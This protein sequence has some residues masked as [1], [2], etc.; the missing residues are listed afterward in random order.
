MKSYISQLETD[1]V[2]PNGIA[3]KVNRLIAVL[4]YCRKEK[5]LEDTQRMMERLQAWKGTFSKKKFTATIE[6]VTTNSKE[7]DPIRQELVRQFFFCRSLNNHI[8]SLAA[9]IGQLSPAE[10]TTIAIY[11]FCAMVYKNWQRLGPAIMLTIEEA[12]WDVAVT[13]DD[14]K[15]VLH[16]KCHKTSTTYGPASLVLEGTDDFVFKE[17]LSKARPTVQTDSDTVLVTSR[18]RPL[19]HYRYLV[20]SLCRRFELEELPTP[21]EVRKSGATLA[22][23]QQSDQ[24][25]MEELGKHMTHSTAT[26]QRHYRDRNRAEQAVSAFEKMKAISTGKVYS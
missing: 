13:R 9:K 3:T 14:G 24:A 10:T 23:D 5:L 20:A 18:G 12:E 8:R 16:S 19:T 15:L 21:T 11:L 1:G 22:V 25:T 7:R 2:G 6:K 4:R 17:F 26:S